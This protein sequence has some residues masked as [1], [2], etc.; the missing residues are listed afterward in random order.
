MPGQPLIKRVKGD[1]GE[2]G[3]VR[4]QGIENIDTCFGKYGHPEIYLKLIFNASNFN[5]KIEQ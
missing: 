4:T 3:K 2:T 1:K 5:M